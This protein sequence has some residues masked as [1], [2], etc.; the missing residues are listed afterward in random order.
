MTDK[1]SGP[2]AR[3]ERLRSLMAERNYDAVIVR[4]EANLRWLTGALGVFDFTGEL[5]HCAFITAGACYLHTDSRYFNS[6]QEKLP[7]GHPWKLDMQVIDIPRWAAERARDERCRVV[8][9]EDTTELSFFDGLVR[10]LS[11]VSIACSVAQMHADIR[12]MRAVKDAEEVELM[13]RAQAITDA[14]FAHMLD[15]IRPGLTEKEIKLELENFMYAQGADGLA[16]GSIVAS[17]PN[18]ANP[19]AIPSD[20]VVEKG[21]FVL[22][23]Y[24]ARLGDYN[25]DMTRTVVLGEPSEEQRRIYDLVRRTHEECVRAIRAGVDGRDIHMLSVKIIS[26]AGYGEYYGHGLGHGVGI[27]IH[28][29]PNFGRRSNVVEEGAVITVEP[30]VYLPGVGGVRLE[31]YGLVTAEGFEPFTRS[32]H[33]L[34]VIDC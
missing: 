30:G 1:I 24:G 33:D 11:D 28:E 5:P 20:R 10:G 32:T 34:Q 6:F 2:S 3:I 17:G 19:H 4:D 22:M 8:A 21:D 13:R 25:S 29:M 23:D 27:D 31:D 18:T 9:V 7:A 12:R 15:F 14:A 16:F 26:D